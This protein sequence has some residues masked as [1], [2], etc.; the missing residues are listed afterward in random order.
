MSYR[1]FNALHATP[2]NTMPDNKTKPAEAKSKPAAEP[3]EAAR[4]KKP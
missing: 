2:S 4:S 3:A 1:E